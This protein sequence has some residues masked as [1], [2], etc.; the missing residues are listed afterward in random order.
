MRTPLC[1]TPAIPAPR[2]PCPLN[3]VIFLPFYKPP[4]LACPHQSSTGAANLRFPVGSHD[5]VPPDVIELH[6][7]L[8]IDSR[9]YCDREEVN[10]NQR[11]G[12][13][14]RRAWFQHGLEPSR[15]AYSRCP[16]G[17]RE[18]AAVKATLEAEGRR[19]PQKNCPTFGLFVALKGC[20]DP[21]TTP[22]CLFTKSHVDGLNEVGFGAVVSHRWPEPAKPLEHVC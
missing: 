1:H 7:V 19:P 6:Q 20:I 15:F 2:T 10:A 18:D 12:G 17:R 3:C 13:G 16:H 5:E 14:R 9:S 22:N 11:S 8:H 4:S 21:A